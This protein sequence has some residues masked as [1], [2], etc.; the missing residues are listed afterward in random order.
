MLTVK[1]QSIMNTE[2]MYL[3]VAGFEICPPFYKTRG[4]E[5]ESMRAV[6]D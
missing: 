3:K 6:G 2:E 4:S 1:R 5:R